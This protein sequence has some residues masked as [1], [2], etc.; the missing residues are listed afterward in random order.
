MSESL[1][2]RIEALEAKRGIRVARDIAFMAMTDRVESIGGVPTLVPDD[3]IRASVID[4]S[5]DGPGEPMTPTPF[6]GMEWTRRQGESVD[7]FLAR[8][9]SDTA[10]RRTPLTIALMGSN[11]PVEYTTS[12]GVV[13][14]GEHPTVIPPEPL[15]EGTPIRP[16]GPLILNPPEVGFE[17]PGAGEEGPA[18]PTYEWSMAR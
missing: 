1:R 9:D 7:D 11:P 14:S 18:Q 17:P 2:R 15:R 10:T 5:Y 3:P 6:G 4:W 13:D 16:R 8:I 12:S